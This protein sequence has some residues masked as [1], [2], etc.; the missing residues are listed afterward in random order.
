MIGFYK[1]VYSNNNRTREVGTESG[2]NIPIYVVVGFQ[3][4]AIA[5]LDVIEASCNLGTTRYPDTDKEIDFEKNKY[6]DAYDGN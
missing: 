6:N 3:S 1:P 4:A 2:T 5:G